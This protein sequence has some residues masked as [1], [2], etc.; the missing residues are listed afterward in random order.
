MNNIQKLAAEGNKNHR[1]FAA[2][3]VDLMHSQGF[4]GRLY[5]SVNEMDD[6]HY[7]QLYEL[8]DKQN[9]QDPLDV[10]LWLKKKKKETRLCEEYFITTTLTGRSYLNTGTTAA[11]LSTA[12]IFTIHSEKRYTDSAPSSDCNTNV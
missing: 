11:G 12:V 5:R 10:V 6:D 3:V 1:I 7:D 2:T 9:F 4:Y 8:I